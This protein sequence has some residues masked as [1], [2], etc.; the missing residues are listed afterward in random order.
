M[1]L[2][3][4]HAN[5]RLGEHANSWYA[6]T[7]NRRTDHPQLLGEHTCDVAIV[8]GGYSGLSTALHLAEKGYQVAI[9]EAHRVAWGASGR[10]GGQVASGQRLD[11]EEL[12]DLVGESLTRAA[13]EI[14]VEAAHL[15]RELIARHA[16]D[17]DYVSGVI[18]ANH[19]ARFDAASKKHADTMAGTYDYQS[20]RFLDK[21]HLAEKIGASGYFGG[22]V[23][24]A[25]GHLHPLNYALGLENAAT[26]GGV[27][28]FELSEIL[29]ISTQPTGRMV[30][31]RGALTAQWIV[32]ACN[33]YLGKLNHTIARCVMPINNYIIATEPLDA[34]TASSLIRDRE[35]VADSRFVVN[36][37]RLSAD[38]RLLFGGGES[39]GY[40]FPRDIRA[41]VRPK[42]L[43]IFPQLAD[44]AIDY[45]WGGTLAITMNRL[46]AFQILPGNII[47]VSGYS[48]SGVA[49]ATMAGK[50]VSEAIDG[51]LSRF[52]VMAK[53]PTP[54]FPGGTAFRTPLLAT[55]MFWY[56]L[57]DLL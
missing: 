8:G 55:A 39:Y 3:L 45:G 6:A 1:A 30:T 32:L 41:F 2:S 16:I 7:A 34:D 46:P 15:V 24:T 44:T 10:N 13:F 17:C 52:D 9:V 40:R 33:G 49:M 5:D 36:Y 43:K 4:L 56:A 12:Q 14:G 26:R 22:T 47:N 27:K 57:R 28:I 18:A 31:E 19:R 50:L 20:I 54:A 11:P 48:G 21:Q 25:S 29:E 38:N 23:D 42:M 37:F 51:Q 35:A 53:L